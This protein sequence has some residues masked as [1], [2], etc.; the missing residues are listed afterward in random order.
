MTKLMQWL[1][2]LSLF[3][4]IWATL[5]SERLLQSTSSYRLHIWL[6]PL[7]ACLTFGVSTFILSITTDDEKRERRL[8]SIDLLKE[9]DRSHCNRLSPLATR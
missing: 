3:V 1:L 7:Y 2:G 6:L 4:T 9:C 8:W 5:L